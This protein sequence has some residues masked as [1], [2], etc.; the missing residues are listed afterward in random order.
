M[1]RTELPRKSYDLPT[2]EEDS[3]L[4]HFLSRVSTEVAKF[5][6]TFDF[7]ISQIL[8]LPESLDG[9]KDQLLSIGFVITRR[10]IALSGRDYCL[11]AVLRGGVLEGFIGIFA[12]GNVDTIKALK[13]MT[14]FR[15]GSAVFYDWL[16][17]LVKASCDKI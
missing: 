3:G 16:R 13:P 17:N 5:D 14:D 11:Y 6:S 9:R 1:E 8:E 12:N 7:G 10:N 15:N 2:W 4:L